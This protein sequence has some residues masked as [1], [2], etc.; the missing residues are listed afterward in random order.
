M[1]RVRD[2]ASC[3]ATNRTARGEAGGIGSGQ[4][5]AG[6]RWEAPDWPWQGRET[7]PVQGPCPPERLATSAREGSPN[8]D[9]E[10]P[11]CLAASRPSPLTKP[12]VGGKAHVHH[13]ESRRFFHEG[14]P[15]ESSLDL[16]QR[17]R[18]CTQEKVLSSDA[19]KRKRRPFSFF[20]IQECKFHWEPHLPSNSPVE[21]CNCNI[22]FLLHNIR[23]VKATT[24][25]IRTTYAAMV[26]LGSADSWP[27]PVTQPGSVNRLLTDSP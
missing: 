12:P 1:R 26:Q 2:P 13:S 9:T 22:M 24:V 10:R 27:D 16:P 21:L 15:L 5:V 19:S 18:P 23:Y 3:A 20:P 14:V 4:S 25:V 6:G 17:R 7:H 8:P 11:P